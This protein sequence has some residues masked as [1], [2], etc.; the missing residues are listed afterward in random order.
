[1]KNEDNIE[2]IKK[3][4]S[5]ITKRNFKAQEEIEYLKLSKK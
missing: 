4:I 5:Y 1:M 2:N 3:Y